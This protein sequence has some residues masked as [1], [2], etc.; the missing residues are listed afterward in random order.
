MIKQ[1]GIHAEIS[2]SYCKSTENKNSIYEQ[3]HI[4]QI[5]ACVARYMDN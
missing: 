2:H 4:E 1:H 3:I 5:N